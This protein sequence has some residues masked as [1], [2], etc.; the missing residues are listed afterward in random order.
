[1]GSFFVVVSTL[2][3]Q[4]FAGVG[5]A[6]ERVSMVSLFLPPVDH[7]FDRHCHVQQVRHA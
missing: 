6:Q 2:I 5:K 4:L 3:L 1:M 7:R